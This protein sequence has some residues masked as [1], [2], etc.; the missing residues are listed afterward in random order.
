MK[1]PMNIASLASLIIGY[2]SVLVTES[3]NHSPIKIPK[4]NI[5]EY[6]KKRNILFFI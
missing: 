3:R 4:L 5:I 6:I 2:L 1:I